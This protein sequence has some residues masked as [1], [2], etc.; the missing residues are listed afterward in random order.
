MAQWVPLNPVISAEPQPDGVVLV[1][2][3]GFL[4]F[5]VCSDSI[6]HVVYSIERDAPNRTDFLVTQKSADP[7]ELRVYRGANGAFTLYE[8]ENDTYDY[9]KNVYA[10]IPFSWDDATSTLTIGDRT[11][12]FPGMLEKR[13]FRIVFVTENL[14]SGGNLTENVDKNVQYSGKKVVVTP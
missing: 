8:D 10:T 1:L 7:I 14:G 11:G 3:S 5:Q 6:V 12:S 13:T 9:E 4:C 2:Q